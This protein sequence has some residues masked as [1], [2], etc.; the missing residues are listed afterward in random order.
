M[1]FLGRIDLRVE[2]SPVS[3]RD[4]ATTFPMRR[5][6]ARRQRRIRTDV[7]DWEPSRP[8]PMK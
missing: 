3:A 7:K 8:E 2:G 5:C 6:D 4:H 1:P